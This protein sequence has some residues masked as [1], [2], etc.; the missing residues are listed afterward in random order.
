M[1]PVGLLLID[2]PTYSTSVTVAGC[3]FVCKGREQVHTFVF[4]LTSD[5][6]CRHLW[7]S[8]VDHHVFFRLTHNSQPAQSPGRWSSSGVFRRSRR[9][10]QR[11]EFRVSAAS[12]VRRQDVAVNRRPSQRFPPR[13]STFSNVTASRSST[14]RRSD[15]VTA[16][17][18]HRF[19][20]RY[21]HASLNVLKL[22]YR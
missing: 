6:A 9:S 10:I 18:T 4:R 19:T 16:R 8:A 17:T 7:K 14:T 12:Y 5:S 1:W 11:D 15:D 20:A 13:R 3:T 22:R 21:V 2:H